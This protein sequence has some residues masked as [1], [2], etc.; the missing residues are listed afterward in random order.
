MTINKQADLSS[1]HNFKRSIL[2]LFVTFICALVM[3]GCS[4][5][6]GGSGDFVAS[7]TGNAAGGGA[8]AGNGSVTF[9]FVRAQNAVVV[10]VNTVNLRIEFFTGLGGTG[11]IVKSDTVPFAATVTIEG[12]PSSARSSVVTALTAE[13]FPVSQFTVNT[14]V[15]ANGTVV[16]DSADGTTEPVTTTSLSSSP[17]SVS[18]GA[19]ST[20]QL[21]IASLFSNGETVSLGGALASNV[22]FTSDNLTVAQVDA[23]GNVQGVVN[24]T[25]TIT[26]TFD[27]RSVTIPIVVGTGTTPP[28]TVDD[29]AITVNGGT[30]ISL[31][32]GAQ[33]DPIAAVATFSNMT[34]Q[35]VD[36]TNGVNFSS[37]V[38]G[39]NVDAQGRI[40]VDAS[41]GAGASG[42]IQ[43]SFQGAVSNQISVVVTADRVVSL[44]VG[45]SVSSLPFGGFE[46]VL[47]VTANFSG[48]S[49]S[50]TV[51][52][53]D[54]TFSG[55]DSVTI[56]SRDDQIIAVTNANGTP[57]DDEIT[58]EYTPMMVAV[59]PP[60]TSTF[61]VNVG[62]VFVQSL[63]VD[64][65]QTPE[66]TNELSVGEVQEFT[67]TAT[68]S[69]TANT[70]VDVSKFA[71]LMAE[72]NPANAP[73]IAVSGNQVTGIIPTATNPNER[74][75]PT[76]PENEIAVTFFLAAAGEN[77][78]RVDATIPNIVVLKEFL[79]SVVYQF[80]GNNVPDNNTVNLPRGYVG[81]FEIVGTFNTGTVRQLNVNEYDFVLGAS[82]TP[83]KAAPGF[84]AISRFDD[85]YQPQAIMKDRFFD[86]LTPLG[87]DPLTGVIENTRTGTIGGLGTY[88]AQRE[89]VGIADDNELNWRR[90]RVDD[91][92]AL[93]P[94]HRTIVPIDL[95]A[96]PTA[97]TTSSNDF[98]VITRPTFR[99][100]VADWRRGANADGKVRADQGGAD[101]A[102][103]RFELVATPNPGFPGPGVP[104]NTVFRAPNG[105]RDVDF[106]IDPSLTG[107]GDPLGLNETISVTV[108][109]PRTVTITSARFVNY[110][111][112]GAI[113]L[114][115]V[116]E[117]EVRVDFGQVNLEE[118]T[119]E[120]NNPASLPPDV[121]PQTNFKLAE[122]NVSFATDGLPDL[123]RHTP[124][125]VG[126][127]G[128]VATVQV[129][130]ALLNV[131]AIP[132]G[133][134]CARPVIQEFPDITDTGAYIPGTYDIATNVFGVSTATEFEENPGDSATY[135]PG[136]QDNGGRSTRDPADSVEI[137]FTTTNPGAEVD[138]VNPLLFSLDPISPSTDPQGANPETDIPLA[139]AF[140]QRF[141]TLIQFEQ[142]GP[143]LDR[144]LD[145]VPMAIIGAFADPQRPAAVFSQEEATVA[146]PSGTGVLL[147]TGVEAAPAN[148]GTFTNPRTTIM[149]TADVV[150][151]SKDAVGIPIQA[152]GN[153]VPDTDGQVSEDARDRIGAG[154]AV[155]TVD[156]TP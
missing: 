82:T 75:S 10:P 25:A 23:N 44:T 8:N 148:P 56:I 88:A 110:E 129:D 52:F 99:A 1:P 108:T 48:N 117:Y 64:V 152:T 18:L 67:V 143:V 115:A 86:G 146:N 97:Q 29:L 41:V 131:S 120:G 72:T 106:T 149:H 63:T 31:P 16:I 45:Q 43:A 71:S 46:Q 87:D 89:D 90:S 134:F 92:Y 55:E 51:P 62:T 53:E 35:P 107:A 65:P 34:T 57:G 32:V 11:A 147:V 96:P 3:A 102:M 74:V 20:T 12:V 153:F 19:G 136:P 9:N 127:L 79:D 21:T 91:A 114:G 112:D 39:I 54:V 26:A 22:T 4:G 137:L 93:T 50:F 58:V 132:V 101:D 66:K 119:Q 128:L 28:P 80:A 27:G 121:E 85:N 76:N 7:P 94:N 130:K 84:E 49:P 42:N 154:T 109:D 6:S 36:Q 37:N 142:G 122:A 118:R 15:P 150:V 68:L 125:E 60:V 116:R 139:V 123:L 17:A 2:G 144:S 104:T 95:N 151:V 59:N 156:V 30:T 126:F 33:S 98:Q 69:D 111:T 105:Q 78:S 140:T 135:D 5:G 145:F 81:V 14:S 113:P 141:R 13:G 124:T 40:T 133:G 83:A 100:V 47:T 73:Q 38:A 138:V 70:V 155:S 24:G 77:G 103:P 61:I